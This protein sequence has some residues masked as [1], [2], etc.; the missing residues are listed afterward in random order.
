MRRRFTGESM[1]RGVPL[2]NADV[3]RAFHVNA[4]NRRSDRCSW[5]DFSSEFR[6]RGACARYVQEPTVDFLSRKPS[7]DLTLSHKVE[8]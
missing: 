4:S 8:L 3:T 7:C 1:D 5:H 6:V 2:G